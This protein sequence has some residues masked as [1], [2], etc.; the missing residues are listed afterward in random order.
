MRAEELPAVPGQGLQPDKPLHLL[1]PGVR[2]LSAI[3]LPTNSFYAMQA[4]IEKFQTIGFVRGA[5]ISGLPRQQGI[6]VLP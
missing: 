4:A 3:D 2:S 6:D 1:H 5:Y